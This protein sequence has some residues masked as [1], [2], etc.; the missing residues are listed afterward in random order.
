MWV[1]GIWQFAPM[2]DTPFK[3]DVQLEPGIKQKAH[4]FFSNGIAIN[5]NSK[6]AQAAYKWARY[7]TSSSTAAKVRIA[8]SWELPALIDKS[9]FADY[10]KVTPP[11]NRQAVFDA[12]NSI[13]PIPVI[14]RQNEM[15]DKVTAALDKAVSGDLTPQQALDQAKKD[16]DALLK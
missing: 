6:N 12:L 2:K 7:L 5:S 16:V 3:W 14:V 9:L 13:V 10:L 11:A 1:N 4:H 8:S 15:Q